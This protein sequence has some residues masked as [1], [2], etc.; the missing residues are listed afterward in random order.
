MKGPDGFV[1]AYNAQ[2]AVDATCQLIVG[3]AVT[4]EANDKQQLVPMIETVA[5]AGGR[6]AARSA[7]RQRVLLGSEPRRTSQAHEIDAYIA[8][9]G[10]ARWERMP[11]GRGPLPKTA[12]LIERMRRKLRTKAGAAVYRRAQSDRRTGL[13]P[14]QTRAGLPSI[15]PARR[16]EGPRRVVA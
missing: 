6:D 13:R 4:Q 3:Q 1:Q 9:D 10:E 2:I 8:T 12:T 7:G 14:D 11:A 15:S 16:G 5:R